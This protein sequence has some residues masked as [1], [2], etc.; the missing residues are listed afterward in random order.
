[1]GIV[2]AV[3]SGAR[4]S[5][6]RRLKRL[7]LVQHILKILTYCWYAPFFKRH[8]ALP[9]NPSLALNKAVTLKA[10]LA[11]F[12]IG[13]GIGGNIPH[14]YRGKFTPCRC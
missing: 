2:S 12:F 13:C 4:D 9:A 5:D 14:I 11:A 6:V 1:M 7:L 3:D 8:C 10:A